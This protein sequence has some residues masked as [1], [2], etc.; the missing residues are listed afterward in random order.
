M[1]EKLNSAGYKEIGT[2]IFVSEED[3][4]QYALERISSDKDLQKEF[5]EWFYSGNWIEED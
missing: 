2:G 4:Y 1:K 3:A 5:V